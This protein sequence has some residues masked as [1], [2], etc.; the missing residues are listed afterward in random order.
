MFCK[1]NSEAVT[2]RYHLLKLKA[3]FGEE[4]VEASTATDSASGDQKAKKV[5]VKAEG[6]KSQSRQSCEGNRNTVQESNQRRQP[7]FLTAGHMVTLNPQ[8]MT[9]FPGSP[10]KGTFY[11]KGLLE[12]DFYH[13]N[14]KK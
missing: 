1:E 11:S 3:S 6:R 12:V 10:L 5:E 9:D 8:K 2:T 7:L 4:T 14:F 13:N